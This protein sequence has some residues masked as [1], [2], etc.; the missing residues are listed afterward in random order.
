MITAVVSNASSKHVIGSGATGERGELFR[1]RVKAL[2][3]ELQSGSMSLFE[4]LSLVCLKRRTQGSTLLSHRCARQS[5]YN[6]L[7]PASHTS[8]TSA[9]MNG[10]CAIGTVYY[11]CMH[12]QF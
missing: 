2:A 7:M 9:V 5:E 8:D 10:K 12:S 6:L 4:G 11:T 1:S 3:S